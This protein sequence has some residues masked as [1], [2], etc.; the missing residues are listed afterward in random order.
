MRAL[1]HAVGT[2]A[3]SQERLIRSRRLALAM[4]PRCWRCSPQIPSGPGAFRVFICLI[5]FS[6]SWAEKAW[7][8][9]ARSPPQ[10][11]GDVLKVFRP[12][13]VR[14]SS[15]LERTWRLTE[16]YVR[17]KA[18]AFWRSSTARRPWSPQMAWPGHALCV[19]P[20]IFLRILVTR[21]TLVR[22]LSSLVAKDLK[23][24][25]RASSSA[26]AA[27]LFAIFH[28]SLVSRE[29]FAWWASRAALRS[30][31]AVTS[32]GSIA[33]GLGSAR[34]PRGTNFW[35]CSRMV[36]TNHSARASV[37]QG[38]VGGSPLFRISQREVSSLVEDWLLTSRWEILNS[39]EP[40]RAGYGE[41]ALTCPDV[42]L[43]HRSTAARCSWSVGADLGSDHLPMEVRLNHTGTRPRRIRKTRWAFHKADSIRRPA[44]RPSNPV[45]WSQVGRP[46]WRQNQS[47]ARSAMSSAGLV[48]EHRAP[49]GVCVWENGQQSVSA[50]QHLTLRL[51]VRP[52]DPQ[53]LLRQWEID[54]G[55]I[56][57]RA[58]DFLR[59]RPAAALVHGQLHGDAFSWI[60]PGA[61]WLRA[62][63]RLHRGVAHSRGAQRPARQLPPSGDWRGGGAVTPAPSPGAG[64]QPA[65]RG[66]WRA[67]SWPGRCVGRQRSAA[68]P[69]PWARG[70]KS[71]RCGSR[72][73]R[74]S[75]HAARGRRAPHE[76][77][78]RPGARMT[79]LCTCSGLEEM[80]SSSQFRALG[81]VGGQCPGESR[82]P[83]VTVNPGRPIHRSQTEP[84]VRIAEVVCGPF[85]IQTICETKERNVREHS[86]H[87]DIYTQGNYCW[88]KTGS[89]K[90]N[91]GHKLSGVT[92]TIV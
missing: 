15:F 32:S 19:A 88:L 66:L 20:S 26:S 5:W 87:D 53:C 74:G 39:G 41:G 72:S 71:R 35:A 14:R 81:R 13:L 40:T 56:N 27:L 6:S 38:S 70:S 18:E 52:A 84:N 89:E 42:A 1:L 55:V 83:P 91:I 68:R 63:I 49:A 28:S 37:E 75:P 23:A 86:Q 7:Q 4:G 29:G 73:R 3:R 77:V 45:K 82:Q 47:A 59:G 85:W 48:L 43:C 21:P 31:M 46:K 92:I 9:S 30:S 60:C 33:H 11:K 50:S 57:Q 22:L 17:T 64:H 25:R 61:A 54:E 76:T 51:T 34:A 36:F 16:A 69:P 2:S 12:A 10:W 58:A 79:S 67:S 24:V 65:V 8:A 78:R 80:E 62:Q 44:A 90:R